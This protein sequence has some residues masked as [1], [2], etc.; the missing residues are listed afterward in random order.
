MSNQPK[1]DTQSRKYIIT[2]NNFLEH[3][4]TRDNLRQKLTSL[5]S[6]IYFCA[7]EEKGHET[8]TH[9]IHLYIAFSSG[10]R[11]STMKNVFNLGG[12]IQPARGTSAENRGINPFRWQTA[13]E[14]V[15]SVCDAAHK[16][17]RDWS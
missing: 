7:S 16:K 1:R 13:F 3:G 9:H 6:L 17:T 14:S 8:G 11:F 5:K 15:N 12:D 2:I 10:V 4:Y